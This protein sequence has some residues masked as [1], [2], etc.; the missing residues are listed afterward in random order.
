MYFPV[1]VLIRRLYQ[2]EH[3]Y[4]REAIVTFVKFLL[5]ILMLAHFIA[6]LWCF[7]GK[8]DAYFTED[9]R[10]TWLVAEGNGFTEKTWHHHYF[11]AFYW[12]FQTITTV[13]YG[14]LGL[15]G[16]SKK[17][18]WFA[19]ISAARHIVSDLQSRRVL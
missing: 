2:K 15:A 4:F 6:C 5:T 10:D 8:Y 12:V 18:M 19:V 9:R 16:S 14:D 3:K 11:F 17:E 1:E 13:G 7:I